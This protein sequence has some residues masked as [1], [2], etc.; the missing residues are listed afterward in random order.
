MASVDY[1]RRITAAQSPNSATTATTG[2]TAVAATSVIVRVAWNSP[3]PPR[4]RCQ[5]QRAIHIRGAD[6]PL[7]LRPI[8]SRAFSE[9]RHA[10]SVCGDAALRYSH[11]SAITGSSRLARRIGV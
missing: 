9:S 8:V 6:P 3:L 4:R 1:L 10:C 2:I 11:R 5:F 7:G